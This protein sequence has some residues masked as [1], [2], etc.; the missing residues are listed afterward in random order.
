MD[1]MLSR[2]TSMPTPRPETFVTCAGGGK[3]RQQHQ[4]IQIRID[5]FSSAWRSKMPRSRAISLIRA[6]FS[7]RPSSLISIVIWPAS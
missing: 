2:T 1:W 5:I 4:R 3:A 7:P 6:T